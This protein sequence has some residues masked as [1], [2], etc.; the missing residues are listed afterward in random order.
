M[1]ISARTCAFA[2][3]VQLSIR[4]TTIAP[5]LKLDLLDYVTRLSE[6]SSSEER[7]ALLLSSRVFVS[8]SRSSRGSRARL[9]RPERGRERDRDRDRTVNTAAGRGGGRDGSC[10]GCVWFVG[11]RE[12][13]IGYNFCGPANRIRRRCVCVTGGARVARESGKAAKGRRWDGK[14]EEGE[15]RGTG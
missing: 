10:V 9:S 7:S 8:G 4:T 3:N 15:S 1:K 6:S 12:R 14:G 13:V 11:P 2:C 5:D